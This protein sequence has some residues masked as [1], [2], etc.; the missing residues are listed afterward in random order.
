[1][2]NQK[3]VTLMEA[4]ISMAVF[5]IISLMLITGYLTAARLTAKGAQIQ[6]GGEEAFGQLETGGKYTEEQKDMTI[7]IGEKSFI[8]QGKYRSG[9]GEAYPEGQFWSYSGGGRP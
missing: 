4:M 1:M 7:T 2:R 5:G 9:Q 3:G 6:K 8:I